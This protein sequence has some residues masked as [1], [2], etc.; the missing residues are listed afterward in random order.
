MDWG[1]I[2]GAAGV[3]GSVVATAAF[4]TRKTGRGRF[5]SP[6]HLHGNEPGISE[7]VR[8]GK[9]GPGKLGEFFNGRGPRGL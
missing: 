8:I 9:E 5:H 6:T 7:V 4:A 3:I 2:A 1:V